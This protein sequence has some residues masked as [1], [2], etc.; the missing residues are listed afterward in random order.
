MDVVKR[1]NNT[2]QE[3]IW[4]CII[5]KSNGK[6][7]VETLKSDFYCHTITS[8]ISCLGLSLGVSSG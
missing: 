3:I 7:C 6:T 1:K 4:D 5:I 8:E 2:I